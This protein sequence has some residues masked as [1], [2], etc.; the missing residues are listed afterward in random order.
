M[1]IDRVIDDKLESMAAMKEVTDA[2]EG[3]QSEAGM[4]EQLD[5]EFIDKLN[6]EH[7]EA[8]P[9]DRH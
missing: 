6:Q 7:R 2:I 1:A 8:E 4:N 3:A 5:K 9:L